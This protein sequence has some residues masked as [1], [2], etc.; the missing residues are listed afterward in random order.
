MLYVLRDL[1]FVF[2]NNPEKLPSRTKA[3]TAE[4]LL[5][6]QNKHEL[7]AGSYTDTNAIAPP[8]PKKRMLLKSFGDVET[9]SMD[10]VKLQR[11]ENNVC[12]NNF[13]AVKQP[14]TYSRRKPN[15]KFQ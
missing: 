14:R 1:F 5:P 11:S 10:S 9:N 6:Y 13:N 2:S 3:E 4:D 15:S 7:E 8:P 12:F